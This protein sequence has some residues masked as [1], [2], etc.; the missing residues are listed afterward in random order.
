MSN[1]IWAT[2]Y[3]HASVGSTLVAQRRL[4]C[5]AQDS[6]SH[7]LARGSDANESLNIPPLRP[8]N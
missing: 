8:R 4:E 1:V 3:S 6:T 5:R 7:T 2:R